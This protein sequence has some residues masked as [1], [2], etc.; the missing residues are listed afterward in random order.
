MKCSAKPCFLLISIFFINFNLFSENTQ[1]VFQ[2]MHGIK[3]L[4]SPEQSRIMQAPM[5]KNA[6]FSGESYF[7]DKKS[8]SAVINPPLETYPKSTLANP[9]KFYSDD[10]CFKCQ[11]CNLDPNKDAESIESAKA[12]ATKSQELIKEIAEIDK[13]IHSIVTEP[14]DWEDG[15]ADVNFIADKKDEWS[16]KPLRTDVGMSHLKK[17]QI[18]R[19]DLIDQV[20]KQNSFSTKEAE[21]HTDKYYVC[22][23]TVAFYGCIHRPTIV[24]VAPYYEKALYKLDKQ[25]IDDANTKNMMKEAI[26]LVPLFL[27]P[28]G[29]IPALALGKLGGH[30]GHKMLHFAYHSKTTNAVLGDVLAKKDKSKKI[31]TEDFEKYVPPGSPSTILETLRLVDNSFFASNRRKARRNTNQKDNSSGIHAKLAAG[32]R[33]KTEVIFQRM[34]EANKPRTAEQFYDLGRCLNLEECSKTS[35]EDI[36]DVSLLIKDFDAAMKILD[37]DFEASRN[38][39]KKCEKYWTPM[40]RRECLFR[41]QIA[42]HTEHKM[43]KLYNLALKQTVLTSILDQIGNVCSNFIQYVQKTR[44]HKKSPEEKFLDSPDLVGSQ[45]KKHS[46]DNRL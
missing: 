21:E 27:V 16:V 7:Q 42:R 32:I 5:S 31:K 41:T 28:G 17:K 4:L 43:G 30:L 26:W 15:A 9:F 44:V 23:S 40:K 10:K 13:E 25:V 24:D 36:S 3:N 35:S 38:D 12:L 45:P 34:A 39:I 37:E 14:L 1:T 18:S 19:R 20:R 2:K 6:C 11:V 22:D 8:C 33:G 46:P 29:L